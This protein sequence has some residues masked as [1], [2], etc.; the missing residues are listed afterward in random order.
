MKMRV[1]FRANE[2]QSFTVAH[3]GRVPKAHSCSLACKKVTLAEL[4][5]C[6]ITDRDLLIC[7]NS[8]K[9]SYYAQFL[10]L[11]NKYWSHNDSTRP[12][13]MLSEMAMAV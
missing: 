5:L 9:S 7:F 8:E 6:D 11:L 13:E 2:I 1:F 4:E 12:Y 3:L 10:Q